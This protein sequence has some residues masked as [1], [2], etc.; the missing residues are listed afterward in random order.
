MALRVLLA[1]ESST[2]KRVISLS[3]QDYPAEVQSVHLGVDVLE[4]ARSFKPDII[5]ADVLLQKKNGYEVCAELKKDPE[6]GNVPVVLI[7]SGFMELDEV[8]LQFANPDAK[9]EKP[10]GAEALRALVKD[11]LAKHSTKPSAPPQTVAPKKPQA[12]PTPVAEPKKTTDDLEAFLT[13]PTGDTAGMDSFLKLNDQNEPKPA[14]D[15]ASVEPRPE[16]QWEMLKLSTVQ[17]PEPSAA[18]EEKN[19]ITKFKIEVPAEAEISNV[20]VSYELPQDDLDNFPAKE[21]TKKQATQ[22]EPQIVETVA[23]VLSEPAAQPPQPEPPHQ[24]VATTPQN[25]VLDADQKNQVVEMVARAV[26]L[27]LTSDKLEEIVKKQAEKTLESVAERFVADMAE[28]VI[29]AELERLLRDQESG[30]GITT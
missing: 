20:T 16:D 11:L 2:I 13:F 30:S 17:E 6:L 7:W 22:P 27:N 8:K 9:L 29:K 18:I 15:P 26:L 4:T 12:P 23:P 19:D 5:F 25:V 21:P 3:L 10:F 24:P 14:P 1:D 28:K